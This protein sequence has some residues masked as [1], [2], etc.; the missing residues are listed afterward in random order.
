MSSQGEG[1][2]GAGGAYIEER[3]NLAWRRARSAGSIAAAL[4]RRTF[5]RA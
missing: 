5:R 2:A 4:T 3:G 1:P